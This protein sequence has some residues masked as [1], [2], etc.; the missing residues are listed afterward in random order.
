MAKAQPQR[1]E[2]NVIQGAEKVAGSGEVRTGY[3]NRLNGPPALVEFEVIDGQAVFEGDIVLGPAADLERLPGEALAGT[4][5][6]IVT[7]DRFR[8]RNGVIP[9]RIDANLANQ[10]RVTNA[11]QHWEQNTSIRFVP[12][13]NQAN[14]LTFRP[15]NECSSRVGMQG[16][17]Q[18]INL[19]AGCSLGSTIHEIGH[20]V[21]LWH[22]Q[23]REDRANFITIN[24]DNI[25]DGQEHNFNQHI[26][27]G[28]DVGNYD[29]G[30]IMHYGA[31]AFAKDAT[32]PTIVAPQAIGQ[33]N[34]L[35]AGDIAAVRFMYYFRRQGDSG[36]LAGA[37]SDIA[38]IRHETQRVVT[39]VRTAENT[40]KLISWAV[41]ANGSFSR[42][43]D[44]AN[45]AGTA[46]HLDIAKARLYVTA[47]RTA[48]GDL[49]LIS[50]DITGAGAI[51]RAGDSGNAAGAA[52]LNCI[53]ALSNTL[54]VTACRTAEGTLKLISWRLNANN[55]ISRLHDSG[56]A[57][58]G[59]SEIAL[60]R[61]TSGR[62]ATAVRA[63][64]G[65]LKVIVWDVDANGNIA[66]KGDSAN[67][68][69]EAR[70]IRMV[71]LPSGD[72]VTSVRAANGSL[73]L[74]SWR[75]SGNGETVT[76]LGDSGNQAGGIGDNALMAR[77]PGVISAVRADDGHLKLIAWEVSGGGAINRQGDS[78]NLAGEASLIAF[79]PESL[80]GSAPIV[81]A[82]RTAEGT[83]KLIS[84][85]D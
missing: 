33:R 64:N 73:K 5:G 77:T 38:C 82:C 55:S 76:R 71:R 75:V 60:T 62:V 84:W 65:S 43:G 6:I 31:F 32:I 27:D 66:R 13:T 42:T 14:F 15:A 47:C 18:F 36:N 8:W 53:V 39:A 70:M 49:K 74:I 51:A 45:A 56:S 21:G 1:D 23:S 17:E 34:G 30:S 78:Y 7:G 69:G 4:E 22:E 26:T 61:M 20:T 80:S 41:N 35:S 37:V 24:W 68:A 40:L 72:L 85:D 44:S 48:E 19:G 2:E 58:G 79:C 9:F 67:Q 11:I 16:N 28:D 12:R 46:S 63:N 10:A 83:L 81:T 57:A 59:V 54:L 52:T 29:Y 50:W 3:L 25:Q